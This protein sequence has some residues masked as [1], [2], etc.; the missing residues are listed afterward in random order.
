MNCNRTKVK[1]MPHTKNDAQDFR[2]ALTCFTV[3][4]NDEG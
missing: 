4:P 3:D 1:N 2:F